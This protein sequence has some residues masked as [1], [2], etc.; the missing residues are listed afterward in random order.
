MVAMVHYLSKAIVSVLGLSVKRVSRHLV[1]SQ[2]HAAGSCKAMLMRD[3]AP[4]YISVALESFSTFVPA[5]LPLKCES[6][7]TELNYEETS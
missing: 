1:A 5:F 3:C 7:E 2:L 6:S 4:L